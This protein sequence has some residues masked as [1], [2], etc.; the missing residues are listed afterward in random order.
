MSA[1]TSAPA[2]IAAP[3]AAGEAKAAIR[4]DLNGP[5]YAVDGEMKVGSITFYNKEAAAGAGAKP[6]SV[7]V[8]CQEISAKLTEKFREQFYRPL[9]M[10]CL[11][12]NHRVNVE[13]AEA[14]GDYSMIALMG[15]IKFFVVDL[16]NDDIAKILLAR[17]VLRAS[18]IQPGGTAQV[19]KELMPQP[20]TIEEQKQALYLAMEMVNLPA[21]SNAYVYSVSDDVFVPIQQALELPDDIKKAEDVASMIQW[22]Q[23]AAAG[24]PKPVQRDRCFYCRASALNKSVKLM[25]CAGSGLAYCSKECQSQDWQ[26]YHK[27]E[28]KRIKT[29]ASTAASEGLL[30]DRHTWLNMT[31]AER[32]SSPTDVAGSGVYERCGLVVASFVAGFKAGAYFSPFAAMRLVPEEYVREQLQQANQ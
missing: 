16:N 30:A 25:T 23:G 28:H 7:N 15:A 3:A 6:G 8:A 2:S 32:I 21:K 12:A 10:A 31:G 9:D 22:R 17:D 27:K 4:A 1:S 13:G 29:G 11:E 5:A 14:V 26:G 19:L 18:L 24:A 20:D